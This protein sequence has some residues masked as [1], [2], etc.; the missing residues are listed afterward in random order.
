MIAFTI[1]GWSNSGKTSLIKELIRFG[2]EQGRRVV[3]LKKVHG[4]YT[5]QP[6]TKDTAQFLQAGADQVYL[7]AQGEWLRL[8]RTPAEERILEI[9]A[10][11]LGERDVLLLEGFG[12]PAVPVIEVYRA[13]LGKGLKLPPERLAAL[14]TVGDPPPG[15]SIPVFS[16]DD[17]ATVWHFMEHHRETR[18]HSAPAG[19]IK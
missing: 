1:A 7:L 3:T 4:A 10:E 15:L 13:E 9:V 17:A 19:G 6:E 18:D 16:A 2:K 14:V 11:H 12:D 8:E 5:L